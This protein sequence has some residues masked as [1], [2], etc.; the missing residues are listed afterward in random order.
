MKRLLFLVL[1]CCFYAACAF[2]QA[3]EAIN[4]K[5]DTM[6]KYM[7]EQQ[8]SQT[9]VVRNIIIEGNAVTRRT[10]FLREISVHEG[11]TLVTDSIPRL[12]NQNKLRLINLS[13]F[14]EIE[15]NI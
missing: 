15:M 11:D 5:A 13:L 3:K 6:Q 7:P 14:N 12:L 10:I 2:G 9:V 8:L 4:N 1:A